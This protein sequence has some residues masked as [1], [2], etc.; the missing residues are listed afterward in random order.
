MCKITLQLSSLITMIYCLAYVGCGVKKVRVMASEQ[1]PIDRSDTILVDLQEI[2]D[3][4][5]VVYHTE[6][7]RITVSY[8][9]LIENLADFINKNNVGDDIILSEKLHAMASE[10]DSI[11]IAELTEEP[12][13]IARFQ[14]RLADM[15]EKGEAIVYQIKTG[16]AVKRILVEHF[17]YMP[18]KL[19]GRG[20]RRFYLPDRTLFFEVIDWIS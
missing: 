18:H 9:H 2:K 14:Y 4:K 3:T 13:L 15:L 12:R 6:T 11:N 8:S 5:A 20:G 16:A 10:K 19:A 7:A 1:Y 17:E